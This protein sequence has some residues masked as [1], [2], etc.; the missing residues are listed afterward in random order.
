[1]PAGRAE[2]PESHRP[3]LA[4]ICA[5]SLLWEPASR[6]PVISAV[7]SMRQRRREIEIT[8]ASLPATARVTVPTPRRRVS[9]YLRP[10]RN[11]PNDGIVLAKAHDIVVHAPRRSDQGPGD[12]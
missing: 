9:E 11:S 8:A 5:A 6:A 7:G 3:E 10:T 1:V 4:L 2:L 12:L